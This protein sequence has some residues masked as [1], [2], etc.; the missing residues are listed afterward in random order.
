MIVSK[1]VA[2]LIVL[3]LA[4]TPW[5]VNA[6]KFVNCDFESNYKCEVI[7]GVGVF[8]PVLSILTVWFDSDEQ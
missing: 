2:T 8:I 4:I 7:H 1:L 3:M 6:T 5:V